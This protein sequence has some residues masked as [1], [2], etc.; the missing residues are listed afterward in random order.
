M[1]ESNLRS[2]G[3]D[4]VMEAFRVYGV[5]TCIT[6]TS[7]VAHALYGP[8]CAL[9]RHL[10]CVHRGDVASRPDQPQ[11]ESCPSPLIP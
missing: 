9:T 8:S 7:P 4:P 11:L 10:R 1:F 2:F 6:C 5:G 3:P